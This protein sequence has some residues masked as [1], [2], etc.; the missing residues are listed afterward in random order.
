MVEDSG[1]RRSSQTSRKSFMINGVGANGGGTLRSGTMSSQSTMATSSSGGSSGCSHKSFW[2]PLDK[3]Q[4]VIGDKY[5]TVAICTMRKSENLDSDEVQMM[6]P[7]SIVRLDGIGQGCRIQV[8]LADDD[9]KT[10][11]ISSQTKNKEA[12]IQA[13]G[14][15]DFEVGGEHEV[16]MLCAVLDSDGNVVTNLRQGQHVVIRQVSPDGTLALV[17]TR[18]NNELEQDLG[19]IS[20]SA[21]DGQFT[22]GKAG[23]KAQ[24]R[25]SVTKVPTGC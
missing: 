16:K 25:D 20:L 15:V 14:H 24:Q 10:G 11:W 4:L 23:A 22:L 6:Q 21:S 19:W 13:F 1:E 5:E 9:S 7:G 2:K 8:T 18:K 17:A 3:S 12:L